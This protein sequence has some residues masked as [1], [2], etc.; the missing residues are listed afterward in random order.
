MRRTILT[1]ALV[2]CLSLPAFAGVAQAKPRAATVSVTQC[3][4]AKDAT[5]GS[6]VFVGSMRTIPHAGVMQM[7]FELL[8]SLNGGPAQ[9]V[10]L[11]AWSPWLSAAPRRPA[12]VYR[13][14]VVGLAGP[15]AY[16][17]R[18]TFRW[19]G[20]R[21]KVLRKVQIVTPACAQPDLRPNL[22]PAK[23]ITARGAG[24][25]QATYKVP[26]RNAGATAAGP[27]SLVMTVNG[28]ALPAVDVVGVAAIGRT[29]VT[30][31]G[32]RC[33]PGSGVVLTVDP[34]GT[35]AESD[36]ADNTVTVP[37]PLKA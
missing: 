9:R 27:F 1:T 7:R 18:I 16:R 11:P 29:V 33:T 24:P 30:V 36:E 14:R 37:C 5:G 4:A 12:Y 34:A 26:V 21:A 8:R 25:G 35:V 10:S 19:L 22:I 28:V 13:K 3:R 6:A 20:A 31:T 17:A 2:A 15:G 32:P 23:A